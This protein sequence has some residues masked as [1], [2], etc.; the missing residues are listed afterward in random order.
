MTIMINTTTKRT[1]MT[2]MINTTTKSTLRGPSQSRADFP[3]EQEV[4]RQNAQR[5]SLGSNTLPGGGEHRGHLF[6][7]D[8]LA[9]FDLVGDAPPLRERQQSQ[10]HAPAGGLLSGSGGLNPGG[11]AE[12]YRDR[13]D[14]VARCFHPVGHCDGITE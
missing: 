2:I 11:Y 14:D 10:N 5:A 3:R 7:N 6:G 12:E 8:R 4:G 9:A 1:A 13:L